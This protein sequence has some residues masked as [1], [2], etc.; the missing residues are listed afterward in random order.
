MLKYLILCT[1]LTNSFLMPN[2]VR[3]YSKY[4]KDEKI[5]VFEPYNINKD[6][7]DS[8]LFFTGGNS[9]IPSEIYSN[10]LS[11][12]SSNNISLHVASSNMDVT[13]LL[14]DELSEEYKSLTVVGH[15]TGC[16]NAIETCNNNKNIKKSVLLDPVDNRFL[17]GDENKKKKI[18]YLDN[19]LFLN[20]KKSYE[21]SLFPLRIPFIP[22]FKL[23]EENLD[24]FRDTQIQKMEAEEFGHCDILNTLWSDIMHKT[25]SEGHNNRDEEELS[26]YHKWVSLII[27]TFISDNENKK[28]NLKLILDSEMTNIKFN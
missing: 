26:N 5:K 7:I 6:K 27:S 23:E 2:P 11:Q 24:I 19:I 17:F 3:V 1:T 4:V 21:F 18:K 9:I 20:A 8:V 13:E 28:R 10:F 25:I 14:A 16:I 12:L 22:A 15:S